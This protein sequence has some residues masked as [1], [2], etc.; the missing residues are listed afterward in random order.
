[1]T[2]SHAADE[3]ENGVCANR[4]TIKRVYIATDACGSSSSRTQTITIN[5]TQGPVFAGV[6]ADI[7]VTN[8]AVPAAKT[9]VAVDNCEGNPEVVFK[10]TSVSAP[11]G[12]RSV[13]TRTWTATDACGNS[14]R[15]AQK[16]TVIPSRTQATR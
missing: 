3:I 9:L 2:I 1:V 10:E 6:P 16:I 14:T 12:G 15:V 4:C 5:D 8:G 7:T 11:K 13:L